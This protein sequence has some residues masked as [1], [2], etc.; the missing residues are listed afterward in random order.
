M[1]LGVA[2]IGQTPRP[3]ILAPFRSALGN[4]QLVVLDCMGFSSA[5]VATARTACPRPTLLAQDVL[6]R[7]VAMLAGADQPTAAAVQSSQ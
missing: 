4:C 6:A 3:D 5:H 7:T 2:T 1:R